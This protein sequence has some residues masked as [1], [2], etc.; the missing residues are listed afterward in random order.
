MRIET[1][2]I[3]N[4]RNI[5]TLSAEFSEGVNILYGL[6]GS[7]KTNLLEAIF[8]L[9]LGRSQRGAGDAIMV[10]G[11]EAVY[12]LEGVLSNGDERRQ[13][14]VAYQRG[15]RK[16]ITLDSVAVRMSELYDGFSIVSI[17]PEDSAILSGAP[18]VR[19]GFLDIYLSQQSG[20]YLSNLSDYARALAQKNAALKAETDATMF[21]ELLIKY[22]SEVV[23]ARHEFLKA[24]EPLIRKYYHDISGGGELAM[25]YVPSVGTLPETPSPGEVEAVFEQRLALTATREAHARLALVGPH[26]DDIGFVIENNPA[27]THAS[28]GEWRTA[29]IA[30]KLAA[31]SLMRKKLACSPVLLLD[32][33]FAELDQ[34]RTT[35]L[36]NLFDD[37]GQL[38][39]TTAGEPPESLRQNGG[40][41]R[42][43][44]GELERMS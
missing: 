37:F 20:R 17:G 13:Q 1:I 12:R 32:E 26:R 6:N 30:L 2:D 34:E 21:D 33:I 9:C 19:R 11:G 41:Y 4:F 35:Y 22:G 14:A 27:R 39:L 29:A 42:I 16:K 44:Q 8:V 31:Y 40:R 23:R 43:A 24:A 38:F 15:G 7:G 18:A 25:Q 3:A 28:Q 10:R 36:I 5:E